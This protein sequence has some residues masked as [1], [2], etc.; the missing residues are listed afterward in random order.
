[1]SSLFSFLLITMLSQQKTFCSDCPL[2]SNWSWEITKVDFN[3]TM[4]SQMIPTLGK[5]SNNSHKLCFS[6]SNSRQLECFHAHHKEGYTSWIISW[7][8]FASWWNHKDYLLKI[9]VEDFSVSLSIVLK[10]RLRDY[11]SL[12][13]ISQCI[14]K[15]HTWLFFWQSKQ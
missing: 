9:Y 4:H 2:Y 6:F 8:R 14:H 7:S 15:W 11:Q 5:A 1:M 13:S 10:L 3:F 12:L